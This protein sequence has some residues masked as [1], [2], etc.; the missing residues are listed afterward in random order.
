MSAI[1]KNVGFTD[2]SEVTVEL[3]PKVSKYVVKQTKAGFIVQNIETMNVVSIHET[4]T[5][6]VKVA[7]KLNN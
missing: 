4:L 2:T 3:Q 6:A 1:K 7:D 5:Q